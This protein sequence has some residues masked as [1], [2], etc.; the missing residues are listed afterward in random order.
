MKSGKIG[1]YGIDWGEG[2][3]D[4]T[5]KDYEIILTETTRIIEKSDV[6]DKEL[7]TAFFNRGI[8]YLKQKD[9]QKA[10]SDF[11]MSINLRENFFASYYNRGCIYY[12]LKKYKEALDDFKISLKLC[13]A[14]TDAKTWVEIIKSELGID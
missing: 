3:N 14:Y 8:I 4:L 12:N 11:T 5:E 7:P 6:S 1:R 10:L 2:E 9:Y 13:P